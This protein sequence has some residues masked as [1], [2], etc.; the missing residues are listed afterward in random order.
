MERNVLSFGAAL[1]KG[2]EPRLYPYD[3]NRIQEGEYEAILDFKIWAKKIMAVGCYFTL[4]PAKEKVQLTVY[5]DKKTGQYKLPKSEIDFTCC[6]TSNMYKIS[7]GK[8]KSGNTY[9]QNAALI[10]K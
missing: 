8:K 10:N 5:C 4:L 1:A 7:I 2:Y 9:L 6:P 3:A